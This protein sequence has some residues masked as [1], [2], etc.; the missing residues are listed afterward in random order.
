MCYQQYAL[1]HTEFSLGPPPQRES[2][3]N[4][5]ILTKIS[6][7]EE[8]LQFVIFANSASI[9]FRD[10]HAVS[11]H[12]QHMFGAINFVSSVEGVE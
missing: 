9:L 1:F 2:D 5:F 10:A 6:I 8:P 12:L 3:R 11:A 4:R 7:N